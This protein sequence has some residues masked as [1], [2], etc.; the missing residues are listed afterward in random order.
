MTRFSIIVIF[1]II[2]SIGL[3]A[4]FISG[5]EN[6]VLAKCKVMDESTKSPIKVDIELK[7]P[8]GKKLKFTSNEVTGEFE[9]LLDGDNEYKLVFSGENIFRTK[10]SFRTD[11]SKNYKEENF[12]FYVNEIKV[13]NRVFHGNLFKEGTAEISNFG[14]ELLNDI[15]INLRFN[16]SV[17]LD[18]KL[19]ANDTDLLNSRIAKVE[20]VISK[21]HTSKS[22]IEI[23]AETKSNETNFNAY[24]TKIDNPFD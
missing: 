14:K 20:E 9:Q 5:Q 10:T 6:K 4:Q 23:K 2:S 17:Y 18:F 21:W 24:V 13:G 3:Q 11:T 19:S 22:R 1:A 15:K 7:T 12:E 8:D 16:R